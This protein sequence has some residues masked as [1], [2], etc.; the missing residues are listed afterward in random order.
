AHKEDQLRFNLTAGR[1]AAYSLLQELQIK[2]WDMIPRV[3]DLNHVVS[4]RA[5]IDLHTVHELSFVIA[6]R[7]SI[8]ILSFFSPTIIYTPKEYGGLGVLI[9]KDGKEK[10]HSCNG[11]STSNLPLKEIRSFGPYRNMGD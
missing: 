2:L 8:F 1:S 5:T 4:D 9:N 7:L 11:S 10:R 6:L 3:P